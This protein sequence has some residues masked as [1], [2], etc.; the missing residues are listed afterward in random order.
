MKKIEHKKNC[1]AY[2]SFGCRAIRSNTCTGCKFFKTYNQLIEEHE[3]AKKRLKGLSP[4]IEISSPY[5]IDIEK[6]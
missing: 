1:F 4:D 5:I 3:K 2:S 6:E